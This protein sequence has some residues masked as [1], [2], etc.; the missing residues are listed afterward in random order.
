LCIGD[1]DIPIEFAL[2]LL[3]VRLVDY[4]HER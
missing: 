1:D 3:V 2:R 4:F